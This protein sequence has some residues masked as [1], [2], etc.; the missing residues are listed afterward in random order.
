MIK[1]CFYKQDHGDKDDDSA[2]S[3]SSSDEDL[4]PNQEE[5]EEEREDK[6]ASSP[7]PGSGYESEESS[8]NELDCY[9]SDLLVK[10]DEG[11]TKTSN[12][13]LKDGRD[14]ACDKKE[15]F[16]ANI[17]DCVIKCRSVYKCRLC[18]RIVCLSEEVLRAHL[19]SKRHDRSKKLFA[20]GRLKL[21]LNSDGEIE[22]DQE[23]HAERHARTVA[24]AQSS[25]N[26]KTRSRGR[27]RQRLRA[28]KKM[29]NGRMKE[30][31]SKGP[32][33][34]PK[35]KRHKAKD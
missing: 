2:S 4:D 11:N 6:G 26:P 34:S 12:Q 3:F 20:E 7:F 27:Q 19:K 32:A 33:D 5:E 9:S 18:P 17:D 21:M 10:K 24:T 8:E 15:P 30:S 23:T 28:R 13:I 1:R 29:L 16:E 31:K 14:T 25:S 22:E 35:K